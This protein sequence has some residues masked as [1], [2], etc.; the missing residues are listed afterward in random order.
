MREHVK[1]PGESNETEGT[2]IPVSACA[3]TGSYVLDVRAQWLDGL[4]SY[5]RVYHKLSA[6]CSHSHT[7][8]GD[9]PLGDAMVII[10]DDDH[11]DTT[12]WRP[13]EVTSL[14]ILLYMAHPE[15]SW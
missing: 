9:A 13:L 5:S 1:S 11:R 7:T 3:G 14:S 4:N 10:R 15:H 8:Y 6:P 12:V 2:A